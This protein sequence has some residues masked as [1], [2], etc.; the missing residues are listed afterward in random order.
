MVYL[1]VGKKDCMLMAVYLNYNWKSILTKE[2]P[3]KYSL[4]YP[5]K[6]SKGSATGNNVLSS[7]QVK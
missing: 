2:K 6:T 3:N 1:W 7:S 5:N 4:L